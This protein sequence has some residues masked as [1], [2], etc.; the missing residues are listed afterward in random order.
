MLLNLPSVAAQA[1]GEVVLNITETSSSG[2]T[3][4]IQTGDTLTFLIDFSCSSVGGNCGTLQIPFNYDET[5]FDRTVSVATGYE[6]VSATAPFDIAI[7]VDTNGI[8][9]G[10][11]VGQ[12]TI[13]LTAKR[14]ITTQQSNI[15]FTL[16]ATITNPINVGAG[17]VTATIPPVTIQQPTEQWSVQKSIIRPASPTVPAAFNGTNGAFATYQVRYCPDTTIGNLPITGAVLIDELPNGI[18]VL[19]NGG[20]TEFSQGGRNYIRWNLGDLASTNGCVNRTVTVQFPTPTFS[21]GSV[22]NN[23]VLGFSNNTVNNPGIC[24]VSCIGE[25]TNTTTLVAPVGEP[26]ISKSVAD[27]RPLAYPGTGSFSFG[28]STPALNV[29]MVNRH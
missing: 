10:G 2:S 20:G 5:L 6:A 24:D 19:N 1:G 9:T 17:T 12:A 28:L 29:N 26:T 25:T 16:Q 23:R 13:V 8:F 11:A 18:T 21:T 14:T 22:V 3:S 4:S 15:P 7:Q 27:S